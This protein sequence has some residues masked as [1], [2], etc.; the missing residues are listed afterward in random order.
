MFYQSVQHIY[1]KPERCLGKGLGIQ[2]IDEDRTN[3]IKVI[4]TC[5][6]NSRHQLIQYKVVHRLHYSRV[7]LNQCYPSIS[8][9]CNKCESAEGSLGHLFWSC[10]KLYDFWSEI[11]RFYSVA[12]SCDL[13]PD[14]A[15]A[16]FGWSN[17]LQ[18]LGHQIKKA[19]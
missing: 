6:I 7:K 9:I 2:I 11:F 3:T 4:N 19:V 17:S 16:V 14:P 8:S 15:I 5:S 13:S 1:L 18:G 12:Y 10:L